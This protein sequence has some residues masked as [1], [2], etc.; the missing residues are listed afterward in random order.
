MAS[1]V[2][3]GLIRSNP[4]R[5][6]DLPYRPTAEDA[7]HDYV[8]AMTPKQLALLLGLIPERHGSFF[9]L[10]ASTGLRIS[11]AI[12]LQWRHVHL[13]GSSPHVKV[14]RGVVRRTLGPH[15]S[16][17]SRRDVPLPVELVRELR[18]LRKDI[19][20]PGDEELVFPDTRPRLGWVSHLPSHLRVAATCTCSTATWGKR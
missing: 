8:R 14:R 20:W 1:A 3:E 9:R 17:H 6:A 13:D 11:E 5:D 18:R 12:A 4:T 16:R 15:K 10:L 2:A 7:E 19:E